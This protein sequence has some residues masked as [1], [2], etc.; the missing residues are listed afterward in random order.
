MARAAHPNAARKGKKSKRQGSESYRHDRATKTYETAIVFGVQ[1]SSPSIGD[2]P[3]LSDE[4]ADALAEPW[5][6]TDSEVAAARAAQRDLLEQLRALRLQQ[7]GQPAPQEDFP[8]EFSA[9]MGERRRSD[10]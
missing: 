7:L 1:T 9:H 4:H 5:R 10:A 8:G 2:L 3:V 6:F